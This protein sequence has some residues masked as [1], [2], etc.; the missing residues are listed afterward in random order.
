MK[1]R[2]RECGAFILNSIVRLNYLLFSNKLFMIFVS[3]KIPYA[4]NRK[5]YLK[6]KILKKITTNHQPLSTNH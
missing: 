5:T 6:Q 2:I 4:N 1:L 3:I